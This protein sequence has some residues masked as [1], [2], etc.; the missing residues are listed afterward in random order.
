MNSILFVKSSH[1]S[2][3]THNG[4]QTFAA[5]LLL[6]LCHVQA[7]GN[8]PKA[9]DAAKDKMPVAK[10]VGVEK[11]TAQASK[12]SV[13]PRFRS[14]RAT[15]RTFLIAMNRREDDPN[16]IEDAVAC[17][18]LS[19]N[20]KDRRSGGEYAFE[21]EFILRSTN[22]PTGV[23]P[24]DTTDTEYEI[25]D[26][27]EIKIH[28]HKLADGRW[29]FA[30][31][32]LEVLP[33]MRL[34]LWQRLIAAG[35]SKESEDIPTDFRSPF[36]M[37]K[38]FSAAMKRQDLDSAAKCLDLTDIPAPARSRL[39]RT[40]V[41]KLSEVLD[42]TKFILLQD[43]PDSSANVPLDALVHKSG[44]ITGER[45]SVG[46]RKGQWTFNRP[47]TS[48]I[49]KLY[50]EFITRPIVPE[51]EALGRKPTI[52]SF[53]LA[54]GLWLRHHLPEF[55]Q[56]RFWDFGPF[57]L[58][59]YQVIGFWTSLFLTI[60]L[61]RIVVRF[62]RQVLVFLLQA[63]N[64]DWDEQEIQSW[65]RPIG[66]SCSL[67]LMIFS[68]TLLDIRS[69]LS[70]PIL[71]VLVPLHALLM[72]YAAFL[73]V[74]PL[75]RMIAGPSISLQGASTLAAMGY[76]VLTL[77]LKIIALSV[78]FGSLLELFDFDVATILAG[79]GI[80][81]LAFALAAQDTLK[82]FFGSVMLIADRTFRVGD[83]VKI[84]GNEGLVESVG[85]RTT[86]LRGLDDS[87][88]TVPNSD[89]TTAHITNYGAR[90]FSR[91]RTEIVIPYG[92]SSQSL[93]SFR[94][95]I[96]ATLRNQSG[97][98]QDKIEVA[99]HDLTN[100]GITLLIQVYFEGADRHQELNSR[101]RFIMEL[102]Q[103]AEKHKIGPLSVNRHD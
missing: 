34:A 102:V 101:N 103:L 67:A 56:F 33:K 21:L 48:S 18:D 78:G 42:R 20:P 77:V 6:I 26:G 1:I 38:Y 99:L 91:F 65:V 23:M 70:G 83:L 75:T 63:R 29:L 54:P 47:T 14:P 62:T 36:A 22:L 68:M 98:R 76:P 93:D 50:D 13:D 66:W 15:V 16:R 32:T 44:Q 90:R 10:A 11:E 37:Y 58:S 59:I 92:T 64:A 39:G 31:K 9:A 72:T 89:L 84:D 17:L 30:P 86:R 88:V 40:L 69:S 80:G 49:D 100:S 25:A 4:L 82:N 79:L 53:G 57:G 41:Y 28:L 74:T 46:P 85:L 43:L 35:Q 61:Y 60:P 52:P 3:S 19:G 55:M 73:L 27:K 81:G 45:H 94:D 24:D 2:F 87:L 71:G 51:L 7:S 8:E 12:S 95:E 96:L 97:I 5:G